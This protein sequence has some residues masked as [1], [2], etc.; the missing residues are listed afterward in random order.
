MKTS[1]HSSRFNPERMASRILDMGD[2]VSLIEQAQKTFDEE[3]SKKL[4]DKIA[5]DDLRSRIF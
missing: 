2:V 3:E 4:A 5:N 1:I